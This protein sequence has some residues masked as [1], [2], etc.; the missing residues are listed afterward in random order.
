MLNETVQISA[1]LKTVNAEWVAQLAKKNERSFS[2]TIDLLLTQAR[3]MSANGA[4]Q[5]DK[6]LAK[7]K[8]G[9]S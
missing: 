1:T 5:T 3:E 2:Q 9:K 6:E 4:N 7:G 8:S